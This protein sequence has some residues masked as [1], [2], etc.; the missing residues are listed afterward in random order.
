MRQKQTSISK[1]FRKYTSMTESLKLDSMFHSPRTLEIQ[2][3]FLTRHLVL[4]I[5]ESEMT[6]IASWTSRWFLQN[7]N[8]NTGRLCSR[9]KKSMIPKTSGKHISSKHWEFTQIR[10][11]SSSRSLFCWNQFRSFLKM[12]NHA[13]RLFCSLRT[14]YS[15]SSAFTKEDTSSRLSFQ[16]TKN[17]TS[18]IKS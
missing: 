13:F 17:K 7:S 18:R 3:I 1:K 15:I 8:A 9:K 14:K 2:T 6:L 11:H 5:W 16:M 12:L 4:K 10:N